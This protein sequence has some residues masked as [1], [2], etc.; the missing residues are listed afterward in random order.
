M[1]QS[2][3]RRGRG[4][5]GREGDGQGFPDRQPDEGVS[6]EGTHRGKCSARAGERVPVFIAQGTADKVVD[7]PITVNFVGRLCARGNPVNF[8]EYANVDHDHI[9]K[10]SAGKALAWMGDRFAGKPAPSNCAR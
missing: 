9:A 3:C 7:P 1:Y 8:V 6:V 5:Q 2:P 10:D 4:P